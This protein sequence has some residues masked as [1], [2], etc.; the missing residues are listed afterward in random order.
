MIRRGLA[1][2]G[3]R[4]ETMVARLNVEIQNEQEK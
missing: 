4:N 3:I 2:S 1:V